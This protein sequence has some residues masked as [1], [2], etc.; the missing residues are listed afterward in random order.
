MRRGAHKL[1]VM[2]HGQAEP[3]ASTDANRELT[4][5]GRADCRAAAVDIADFF[6]ASG[7][8]EELQAIYHSP[9]VRTTQSALELGE[10]LSAYMPQPLLLPEDNLLGERTPQQVLAWLESL[11]NAHAVYISHQPLVSSL[12]GYLLDADSSRLAGRDYPMS[13]ASYACLEFDTCCAGGFTLAGLYHPGRA[14]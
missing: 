10:A 6:A 13:P 5:K 9:F 12:L 7:S 2:R 4:G 3:L 14:H 8:G 1:V 11:G